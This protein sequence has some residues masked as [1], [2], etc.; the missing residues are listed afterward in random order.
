M[1]SP[2]VD[3]SSPNTYFLDF[4][5]MAQ[6]VFKCLNT[7][8]P[9]NEALMLTFSHCDEASSIIMS[10]YQE[11]PCHDHLSPYIKEMMNGL[12]WTNGL[13]VREE[14]QTEAAISAGTALMAKVGRRKKTVPSRRCKCS[15]CHLKDLPQ[16][17]KAKTLCQKKNERT[18]Y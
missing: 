2:S 8:Q 14:E 17:Q 11:G 12:L 18:R 6:I 10:S 9:P 16:R 5:Q 13:G 3:P 1:G 4:I 15:A 7:F